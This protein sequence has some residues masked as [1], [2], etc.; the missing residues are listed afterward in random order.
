MNDNKR[1]NTGDLIIFPF[2]NYLGQ[3]YYGIVLSASSF[4]RNPNE[5]IYE[6]FINNEIKRYLGGL[7]E[8]V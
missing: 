3:N 7:I 2:V 1:F 5:I 6:C 8:K 4:K